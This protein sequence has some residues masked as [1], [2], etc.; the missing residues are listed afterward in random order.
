MGLKAT[1]ASIV[2]LAIASYIAMQWPDHSPSNKQ[3]TTAL[4]QAQPLSIATDNLPPPSLNDNIETDT[5]RINNLISS[6][7]QLLE[8]S[9]GSNCPDLEDSDPRAAF[10]DLG[11]RIKNQLGE[12]NNL[13]LE[14]K[15]SDDQLREIASDYMQYQ[16]GHVQ[17]KVLSILSTLEPTAETLN[18]ILSS[19]KTGYDKK[20][21]KMVMV[22]FLRYPDSQSRSN[23]N[24]FLVE[25]LTSGSHYVAQSV[26]Q[27]IIPLLTTDNISIFEETLTSLPPNTKKYKLLKGS[28][29]EFRLMQSNG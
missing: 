4:A 6:L 20:I 28:I 15:I 21:I 14:N 24:V 17:E 9:R 5:I 12:L 2:F 11:R 7:K 1:I 27:N 18:T 8:C 19:V 10:F 22:E 16:D 26:A 23:I 13:Y 3:K 29:E 25:T